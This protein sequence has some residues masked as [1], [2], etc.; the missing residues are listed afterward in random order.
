MSKKITPPSKNRRSR[1]PQNAPDINFSPQNTFELTGVTPPPQQGIRFRPQTFEYPTQLPQPNQCAYLFS[2]QRPF[3]P[4]QRVNTD[5]HQEPSGSSYRPNMDFLHCSQPYQEHSPIRSTNL[6]MNLDDWADYHNYGYSTQQYAS[7]DYPSQDASMGQ[8]SGHGSFH[9]SMP[10]DDD[11]DVEETSPVKPK[12]PSRRATKAKAKGKE[13]E[14][15]KKA[16][17]WSNKEEV[18]LCNAFI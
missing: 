15:A 18:T 9:G 14:P 8:G 10:V 12:K 2:L 1:L 16:E 11:D 17:P 5:Y 7:Q 13:P 6:D 4:P 3:K